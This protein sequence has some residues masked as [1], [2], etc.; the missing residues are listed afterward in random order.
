MDNLSKKKYPTLSVIGFSAILPTAPIRSR[1]TEGN[2]NSIFSVRYKEHISLEES[3]D[4]LEGL[5]I[6]WMGMNG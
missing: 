2:V 4:G 6:G 1:G 5:K 3:A